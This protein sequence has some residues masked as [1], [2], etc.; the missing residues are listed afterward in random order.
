[1][2]EGSGEKLNPLSSAAAERLRF[3]QSL[4]AWNYSNVEMEDLKAGNCIKVPLPRQMEKALEDEVS[5]IATIRLPLRR[6][7]VPL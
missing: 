1:M 4:F 5:C 7:L 6:T 2:A 3:N